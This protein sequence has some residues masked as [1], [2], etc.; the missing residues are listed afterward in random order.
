MWPTLLCAGDENCV[1][2]V[3]NMR[4][5]ISVNLEMVEMGPPVVNFIRPAV[6]C[7]QENVNIHN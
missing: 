3:A 5:L 1:V 6:L 4:K 7:F 2:F